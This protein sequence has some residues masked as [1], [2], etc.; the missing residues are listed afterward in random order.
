MYSEAIGEHRKSLRNEETE[1]AFLALKITL[2]EH[3]KDITTHFLS[4]LRQRLIDKITENKKER[5]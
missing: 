3:L 2:D 1:W 4:G 5:N